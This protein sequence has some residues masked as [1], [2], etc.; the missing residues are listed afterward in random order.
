MTNQQPSPEQYGPQGQQPYGQPQFGV[1]QP[2]PQ[3]QQPYGQQYPPQQP[4]AY[5]SPPP[6][7]GY[8][9][10]PRQGRDGAQYVRQQQAHSLIKHLMIGFFCMWINVVYISMS[11]NHYWKA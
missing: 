4:Y 9:Q 11:P 6:Q 8:Q 10:N 1:Q 3:Q 2:G 7:Y 5:Q